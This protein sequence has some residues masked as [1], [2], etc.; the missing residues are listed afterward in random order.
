MNAPA[1]TLVLASVRH[2]W[3][4]PWQLTLALAG[5]AL[6]VA[7][8][9]ALDLSIASSRIAFERSH[10]AVVGRA[11]HVLRADPAGV[12]EVLYAALKRR[13]LRAQLAPVVEG[14]VNVPGGAAPRTLRVIGVDVFAE[15]PFRRHLRDATARGGL[16]ELLSRPDAVLMSAAGA[17]S[18]GLAP[19]SRFTVRAGGRP[20]SFELL[21]VL[22]TSDELAEAALSDLVVMDIAAAQELFERIGRLSRVDVIAEG[23]QELAALAAALPPGIELRTAGRRQQAAA[24]MAR[25]FE[26]NLRMLGLLSLVVGAFLVY[27]TMA[28]S[29][30]RRRTLIARF[31]MLGVTRGGVFGV[32]IAEALVLSALAS[33]LGVAFGAA[34]AAGLLELVTRS[35]NDHYFVVAVSDVHPDLLGLLKGL[36]LGT[37]T[38]VAGAAFP[39]LEATRVSPR[40]ASLPSLLEARS[41]RLS[42]LGGA[43]GALCLA[44]AVLLVAL[45]SKDPRL[46][47]AALAALV[48]GCVLLAPGAS[49]IFLHAVWRLARRRGGVLPLIAARAAAAGLSRSALAVGALMVALAAT[50]GVGVMVDSFRRSVEVWLDRT[51][52]ADLYVGVPGRGWERT[53]P[54]ALADEIRRLPGVEEISRGRV[55]PVDTEHGPARLFV[56]EMARRSYAAFELVEGRG[57]SAWPAFDTGDAVLASEPY[58]WRAGLEAGGD[59][60][61]STPAGH[62]RFEV[63][64]V[65][66]DYETS[67]GT[68]LMGRATYLRHWPERGVSGI[69]VYLSPH[70]GLA[71]VTERIRALLP[72]GQ[73][74]VLRPRGDIRRASLK[75]FDRTFAITGVLRLLAC[76]VAFLGVLSALLALSLERAREVA[77]MRAIGLTRG[78][79]F[80]LA[81]TETGLLGLV[82][83]LLAIPTGIAMALLLILVINRRSFGWGLSVHVDPA[84]CLQALGLALLAA[85]LAGLVPAWRMARRPPAAALRSE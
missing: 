22:E 2:A 30:V 65:Y 31:R 56:I 72:A 61:L 68:L 47:F 83:G 39:A 81:Q 29:V 3:R 18:L 33:A 75:V 42:A 69:G 66:R 71:E 7:V 64:G 38:G 36:A 85:L 59:I 1:P 34:L 70:G 26:L 57:E 76:T 44:G 4:H 82:A 54:A 73:E 32:L 50:L 41:T 80:V 45:P 14:Y 74:I 53:L 63:A 21:G 35:L 23:A 19:G 27:N 43:L 49:R 8:V 51:L 79:V 11:T 78:E 62:R 48:L 28:F 46:G 37:G 10:A 52:R 24:E 9:S 17:R 60:V 12:D 84:L 67:E 15:G 77:V 16:S 6:G 55:L 5:V 58:A 20:H 25:A 40:E 13:G